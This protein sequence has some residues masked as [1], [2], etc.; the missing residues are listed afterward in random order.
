MNEPCHTTFSS[1][2]HARVDGNSAPM[3]VPSGM[4]SSGFTL[5]EITVA[6]FLFA[7]IITTV[8]GSFRAVFSSADA[9]G[10]DIYVYQTA[11]SCLSR[12]AEDLASVYISDY[13]RY[14]KPEFND[15]EDIYRVLGEREDIRGSTFGRLQFASLAHV[16][17]N[18]DPRRGVCRI[19]Y[20][21]LEDEAGALTVRRADTLY[22][23]PEFEPSEDDPILCDNVLGLEFSYIDGDGESADDWDSDSSDTDYATPRAVVVRLTVGD[24]SRPITFATRM[25]LHVYREATE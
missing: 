19:V 22:P 17:L 16:A 14:R 7:V 15:A 8:F 2:R 6:I 3:T 4:R 9:V 21:V 25:P 5:L 12:M 23:F 13:P 18:R 1:R 11:R 10:G 24:A 20:Y